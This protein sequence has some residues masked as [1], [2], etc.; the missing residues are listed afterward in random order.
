M[1]CGCSWY[2]YPC[3]KSAFS[4]RW[5]PIRKH[6]REPHRYTKRGALFHALGLYQYPEIKVKKKYNRKIY[7]SIY[8]TLFHTPG[9]ITFEDKQMCRKVITH[10]KKVHKG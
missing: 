8:L 1:D 10:L 5:T 4:N 7:K 9:N 6:I 3:L 2:S